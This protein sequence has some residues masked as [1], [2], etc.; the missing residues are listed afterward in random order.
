[1][2]LKTKT[3]YFFFFLYHPSVCCADFFSP[4]SDWLD[5]CWTYFQCGL[6]LLLF[7]FG[8][9][10]QTQFFLL[11]TLSLS[12]VFLKSICLIFKRN[13]ADNLTISNFFRIQ[14]VL[15]R[16]L[17][18]LHRLRF[19]LLASL[20]LCSFLFQVSSFSPT[21]YAFSFCIWKGSKSKSFFGHRRVAANFLLSLSL[22]SDLLFRYVSRIHMHWITHDKKNCWEREE[23][24]WMKWTENEILRR[25]SKVRRRWREEKASGRW[26]GL[27]FC[28][29]NSDI[30]KSSRLEL[31]SEPEAAGNHSSLFLTFHFIRKRLLRPLSC[32]QLM[33]SNEII[34]KT[35]F[36]IVLHPRLL[37][38]LLEINF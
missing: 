21:D 15:N 3:F 26:E 8:F 27:E 6:F 28:I 17:S 32:L 13:D 11:S 19:P 24:T 14:L 10:V 23:K 35:E 4:S 16:P 37:I 12:L 38:N 25:R 9:A 1:M 33:A 5:T 34:I 22:V 18:P 31:I 20:F 30:E 2:Q 29:N 36:R 7:V